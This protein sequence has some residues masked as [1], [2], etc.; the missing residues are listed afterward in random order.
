MK[1]TMIQPARILGA[2]AAM[3]VLAMPASAAVSYV[4]TVDSSSVSGTSG[5]LDFQFNPG[6][7]SSQ[8]ATAAISGFTGG[9]FSGSPSVTGDGDVSGTL[10]GTLT[11]DNGTALNEYFQGF[12]FP[13]TTFS[14]LLTLSGPALDTPNGIATAG[15]TFGL[16]LYDSGQDPILTD[17]GANTGFA[18]Q[19]DILLNGTTAATAFP[20]GTQP[21]VVT[22]QVQTPEPG[23]ML[24]VVAGLIGLA[25]LR[26]FPRR[27]AAT[28]RASSRVP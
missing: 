13:A 7:G 18:G 2:L 25:V 5:F 12:T 10:P 22:F 17:Q 3:V 15:S 9:T 4:V 11:M 28:S 21:T 26:I 20:N 16:G 27:I 19:V 6:N 14:F 1:A 24:L 23:S 8:P